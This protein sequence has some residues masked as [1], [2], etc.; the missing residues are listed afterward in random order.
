M[1]DRTLQDLESRLERDRAELA[2][3]LEALRD[4]LSPDSLLAQGKDALS[5]H[6]APLLSQVDGAI[7]AHP[8]AAGVAGV[9]L[10]AL[11]FGRRRKAGAD[12]ETPVPATAG[13]RFEAISRWEDEGGPV[14]APPDPDDDWMAEADG[15]RARAADLL[16]RLDQVARQGLAPAAEIARNRAD[17][18]AALTR[19]TRATFGKGLENLGDMARQQALAARERAYTA[20]L[21]ARNAGHQT[22]ATH[23]LAAG[24]AMAAAGAALA[25][26][27]RPTE[28]E[29]RLFGPARDQ[30]VDQVQASARTEA[31]K[32]SDLAR[33]LA[34]ALSSDIDRTRAALHRAAAEGAARPATSHHPRPH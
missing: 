34:V 23:P 21:A 13:T 18:L 12:L 20:R 11:V 15:L 19:D 1:S 25:C 29:D 6:A 5:G 22:V 26:L 2:G 14:M 3:S 31:M 32:A 7:R 33:A 27:F 9:A 10:A 8:F 4:R 17:V 24:A 30:L 16:A 28:A